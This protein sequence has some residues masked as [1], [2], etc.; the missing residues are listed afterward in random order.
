MARQ[1]KYARINEETTWGT[2]NTGDEVA[3]MVADYNAKQNMEYTDQ[4][5][6]A[7][8]YKYDTHLTK[9][10][11]E[12]TIDF[13]PTT[14]DGLGWILKHLIGAPVSAV[15]SGTAYGHTF[16][17]DDD[18]GSLSIFLGSEDLT[19][20]CYAGQVMDNVEFT[21][22]DGEK[23]MMTV[24]TYG[25]NLDSTGALQSATF[26][27]LDPFL[28]SNLTVTLD[29]SHDISQYVSAVTLSITNN[30]EKGNHTA[31]DT[32]LQ[33]QPPHTEREVTWKIEVDEYASDIGT[34]LRDKYNDDDTVDIE[35]K[36]VGVQIAATGEYH[37]IKFTL[38]A[39]KITGGYEHPITKRDKE[40]HTFSG[41][42]IYDDTED[43]VIQAYLINTDTDYVL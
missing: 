42:A 26:T 11:A 12:V 24:N 20:E 2:K 9:E 32:Q 22:T 35:F 19:E 27:E 30:I 7:H 15:V 18:L 36:W 13:Y 37:T 23:L 14:E 4:E 25:K 8:G 38:P 31:G 17:D 10:S 29:D 1:L 43:T 34:Y 41:K 28:H 6:V 33:N 5:Q 39:A 16:E 21:C 3:I 40:K